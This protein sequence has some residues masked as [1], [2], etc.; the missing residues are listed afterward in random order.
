[1]NLKDAVRHRFNVNTFSI[2]EDYFY[3]VNC[4]YH[5]DSNASA[6]LNFKDKMFNCLAGCGAFPFWKIAK[7]LNI[8]YDDIDESNDDFNDFLNT[9]IENGT[10]PKPT[11][12]RKQVEAYTNFLLERK[13]DPKV[14]E[15]FGGYY[16]SDESHQDYGHLVVPYKTNKGTKYVRRR[17]LG[18]GQRFIQ[19]PNQGDGDSKALLGKGF[20]SYNTIILVEGLTDLFTI[21][22]HYPNAVA[23]FGCRF[24][25]QQGYLLRNKTVFILYDRDYEGYEGSKKAAEILREYGCRVIILEI[26]DHFK[27][28]DNSHKIDPNSAY[29]V[30]GDKFISWLNYEINKYTS[31]DSQYVSR[32]FGNKE[33][34]SKLTQFPTGIHQLD[35]M[36][37]G[38]FASGIHG[39]AGR[40]GIG[41]SSLITE[42]TYKAWLSGLKVLSLSYELSKEQ[43]YSRLA[44]RFSKFSWSEIEKD[45]SV[46]E[47][48]ALCSLQD[49]AEDIKVELGWN[50]DQIMTAIDKFDVLIVDYIQRMEFEGNDTRKG[51][52]LNMGKLSN[53]ARDK[54]KIIFI[55]SSMAEGQDNFKESGSILYMCQTG[56]YLR[57]I[58]A[59]VLQWE[60]IKHTRGIAGQSIFID[61]SFA[62]QTIKETTPPELRNFV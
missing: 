57:R 44:S 42:L 8:S 6:G 37:N 21:W 14:V 60:F 53:L 54:N 59:N 33:D 35:R 27:S 46:L 9:L 15:E 13:I 34:V 52:D 48:E 38:G 25:K 47:P 17:I 5:D 1:M 12:L 41:K 7:D 23:S 61:V 2:L 55:I 39:I 36:L 26:P 30:A 56:S 50:I 43:M 24:T 18:D 51:I 62:N 29:C 3:P 45:K 32:V 28:L 20:D 49:M 58:N 40:S 16:V 19:S 4:P 11:K 22:K 10:T 31:Y